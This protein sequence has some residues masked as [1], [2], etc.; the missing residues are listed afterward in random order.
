MM[1]Y[2]NHMTICGFTVE[3]SLIIETQNTVYI[4]LGPN[5]EL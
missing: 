1:V 4:S 3:I 2:A 5:S